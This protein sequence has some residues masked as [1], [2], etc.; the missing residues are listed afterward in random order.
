M[1][2][3]LWIR[4]L[5]LYNLQFKYDILCLQIGIKVFKMKRTR[6][7]VSH[8]CVCVCVWNIVALPLTSQ[9]MKINNNFTHS[10]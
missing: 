4:N 6:Q 10:N 7:Y 1:Y 5:S 2:E 9:N 8:L 3:L